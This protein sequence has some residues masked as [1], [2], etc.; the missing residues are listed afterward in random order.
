MIELLAQYL[1]ACCPV[2]TGRSLLSSVHT[3]SDPM[4]CLSF[5]KSKS[6]N[7]AFSKSAHHPC[8][9]TYRSAVVAS[10]PL[11]QMAFLGKQSPLLVQ[12]LGSASGVLWVWIVRVF[13]FFTNAGSSIFWTLVWFSSLCFNRGPSLLHLYR[14]RTC[15]VAVIQQECKYF[16]V[17]FQRWISN[18]RFLCSW[19]QRDF[20]SR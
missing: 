10:T 9:N 8:M 1:I 11:G 4:P 12:L 13:F 6:I 17:V 5:L 2:H 18:V 19:L 3:P 16:S 20:G 7:E 15:C 14:F